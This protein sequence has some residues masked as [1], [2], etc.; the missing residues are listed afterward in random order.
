[1]SYS[2]RARKITKELQKYDRLLY[3]KDD[4]KAIRIFRVGKEFREEKF[5]N[6]SFLNLVRND[7]LVMSLTDT[8]GVRG[9][10]V[11]WG[12]EPIMARIKALDLW[13]SDNLSEEFFKNEEIEEK[14]KERQMRNNI[15]SFLYEF[16]SQFAKAT[17]GIN[18]STLDK[19]DK[20]RLGDKKWQS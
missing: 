19:L 11:D 6:T 20:R 15:E 3:A 9:H 7:H 4:G 5:N 8:W 13:N 17:D 1:M 18:T 2:L 14:S 12:I 16:K 10:R